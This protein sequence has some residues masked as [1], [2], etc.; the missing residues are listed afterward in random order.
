M[1]IRLVDF[2]HGG[3]KASHDRGV[4]L[5]AHMLRLQ[6]AF[7]SAKTGHGQTALQGQLEATDRQIDQP[8]HGLYKLTDEEIRCL[9]CGNVFRYPPGALKFLRREEE[10]DEAEKPS[11]GKPLTW[12]GVRKALE[13]E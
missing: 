9:D 12:G 6:S 11:D 5:V 8:V 10:L 7:V 4:E 3:E 13:D 1:P 2:P